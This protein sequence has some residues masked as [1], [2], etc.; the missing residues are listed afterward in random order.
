MGSKQPLSSASKTIFVF[1]L[2][3]CATKI[4]NQQLKILWRKYAD[5]TYY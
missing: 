5:T 3:F 1:V 2:L 4:I